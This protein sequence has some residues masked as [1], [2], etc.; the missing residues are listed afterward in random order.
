MYV[1]NVYSCIVSFTSQ[2]RFLSHSYYQKSA[3]LAACVFIQY[4]QMPEFL[5]FNCSK[6]ID[7]KQGAV[8]AVRYNGKYDIRYKLFLI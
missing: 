3:S 4:K 2:S 8:R 6:V 7:C 1:V 5:N